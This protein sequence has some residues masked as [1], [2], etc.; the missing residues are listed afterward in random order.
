MPPVPEHSLDDHALAEL[1]RIEKVGVC[2]VDYDAFRV[3]WQ[4]RYV[5]AGPKDTHITERGR[6][7]VKRLDGKE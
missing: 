1:R 2:H 7:L 3:L 4:H 6:R 5:M